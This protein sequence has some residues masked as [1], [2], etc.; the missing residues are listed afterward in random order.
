M[1]G[2]NSGTEHYRLVCLGISLAQAVTQVSVL[3]N[4]SGA[5]HYRLVCLEIT[6]GQAITGKCAWE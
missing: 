5:G 6:L 2:N 3:G 4:N 1:L